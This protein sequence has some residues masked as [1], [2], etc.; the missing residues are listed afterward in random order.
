MRLIL[1]AVAFCFAATTAF[2]QAP[3][4]IPALDTCAAAI[5]ANKDSAKQVTLC[6]TAEEEAVGK[7]PKFRVIAFDYTAEAMLRNEQGGHALAHSNF[8][9]T[10]LKRVGDDD[11]LAARA[12][13][14]RSRCQ[15]SLKSFNDAISDAKMAEDF[16]RK[17]VA[18]FPNDPA[19]KPMLKSILLYEVQLFKAQGRD[20]DAIGK[21][22]EANKL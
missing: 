16:Q 12:Y 8:A 4:G 18:E 15:Q 22:A 9:I 7:G 1:A 14:I 20:G 19:V 13:L 5:A 3:T 6:K 11:P 17:A 21:T 10:Y 2:A